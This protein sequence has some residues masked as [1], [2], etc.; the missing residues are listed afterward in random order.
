MSYRTV[1]LRGKVLGCTPVSNIGTRAKSGGKITDHYNGTPT[2]IGRYGGGDAEVIKQI[3]ADANYQMVTGRYSPGFRVN[4]VMYHAAVHEDAIYILRNPDAVLWHA[5]DA[6]YNYNAYA[7]TFLVGEGQSVSSRTLQTAREFCDD[8][9]KRQGAASRAKV[10]GHLEVSDLG[11]ACP[12]AWLMANFVRP[13]RAGTMSNVQYKPFD[14]VKYQ[15]GHAGR[16]WGEERANWLVD[17]IN[18]RS[19]KKLA[20]VVTGTNG[21]GYASQE[22]LSRY[23][24][25]GKLVYIGIGDGTRKL[26]DS[27]AASA[28]DKYPRSE[29]DV[30]VADDSGEVWSVAGILGYR[31]KL[32][33]LQFDYNA[34]FGGSPKGP[35]T[36]TPP[37]PPA[38][39]P[40]SPL[41][42]RINTY[43][44][45]SYGQE[46]VEEA[47]RA[48]L[49]I[50][51]ACALV[52]QESGG[53][54]IFG[55]DW[56]TRGVDR[57]PFAH[58]PVADARVKALV[59]HVRAGGVSNGVGLTQL[60]W[61]DFIYEAEAM[62][63]AHIP[64]YQLRVGFELLA[65]YFDSY[66]EPDG[67]GA[68]NAGPGNR[69]SVR[70]SYSASCMTKR[71]AWLRRL[72]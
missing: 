50:A 18:K 23:S 11:T 45:T 55:A 21:N 52:E 57:V 72:A 9:L 29:S 37:R 67:W 13:Y 46:I 6:D 32:P 34:K 7:L 19:G 61:R 43:F 71:N 56:G 69:A 26:L 35:D 4:G 36:P 41:A 28:V 30:W 12:G 49:H 62:G 33:Q 2:N 47:D 54:N 70:G 63:G 38:E 65:G 44:G 20:Q 14:L 22:A 17:E 66:G 58:M 3:Q 27:G 48:G 42:A 53:K 39:R 24:E 25:P 59:A 5:A 51:A 60:T 8:E 64:R 16:P 1:D 68:Y 10:V 15:I 31:E 40:V